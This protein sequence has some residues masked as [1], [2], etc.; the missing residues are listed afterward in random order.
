MNKILIIGAKGFFCKRINLNCL[1]HHVAY[2]NAIFASAKQEEA[3]QTRKKYMAAQR[4]SGKS[5]IFY[6]TFHFRE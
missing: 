3:L 1:M 2:S 4:E 5:Q 6:G